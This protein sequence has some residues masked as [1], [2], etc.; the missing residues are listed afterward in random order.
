M[1]TKD[2][3]NTRADIKL[4][5]NEAQKHFKA[6]QDISLL[7][8]VFKLI[9]L[10]NIIIKLNDRLNHKVYVQGIIYDTI[11][12]LIA[13]FTLRERYLQ[14]NIRSMIEHIARIALNKTYQGGDFDGTVRRKD[15]DHLK[16]NKQIENWKYMHETYIRA[17]QYL[18]SSPQAKLNITST[19]LE[20]L[21]DDS[22]TKPSKQI[23]NLQK[24]I[25]ATTRIFIIY[26]VEEI[27]STFYRSQ[28]ELKFLLGGSLYT[29]YEK[30]SGR[31]V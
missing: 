1:L 17:C 23:V 10:L 5:I 9:S 29:F 19:F 28:G 7:V 15:F 20:L 31:I 21:S 12:A 14:L 13:I 25:S 6:E 16:K 11:N 26:Y 3:F 24:I 30:T 4:F 18:H 27:S 8:S 22:T 2:P